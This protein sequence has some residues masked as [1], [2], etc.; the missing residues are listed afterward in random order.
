MLSSKKGYELVKI[1]PIEK[2]LVETDGP[3]GN[4]KKQALFPWNAN[5]AIAIL[6]DIWGRNISEAENI[7]RLNLFS[8]VAKYI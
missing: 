4:F 8:V 5:V 3:L 7:L 2:I 6:A 1:M